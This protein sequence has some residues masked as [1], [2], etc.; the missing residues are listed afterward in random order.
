MKRNINEFTIDPKLIGVYTHTAYQ[1]ALRQNTTSNENNQVK[2]TLIVA[3][4]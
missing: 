3:T 1:L 2:K 4:G